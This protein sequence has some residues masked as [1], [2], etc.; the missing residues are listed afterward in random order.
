MSRGKT[1]PFFVQTGSPRTIDSRETAVYDLQDA[2]VHIFPPLTEFLILYWND[3]AIPLSYKYDVGDYIVQFV[4]VIDH[5]VSK[6][7]GS[8]SETLASNSFHTRW[9]FSWDETIIRWEA[10]WILAG[11]D[12]DSDGTNRVFG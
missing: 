3:I 9:E 7:S 12:V 10:K 6:P 4:E 11:G 8:A 2:I 1:N 5:I